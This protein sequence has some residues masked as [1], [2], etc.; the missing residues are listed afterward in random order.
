MG[1]REKLRS[2]SSKPL[3]EN[4][5][6]SAETEELSNAADI[7][8]SSRRTSVFSCEDGAR[9][10]RAELLSMIADTKSP[11][12]LT[13]FPDDSDCR[14]GLLCF[15]GIAV[16]L[17]DLFR[18]LEGLQHRARM[19]ELLTEHISS[20]YEW[21]E[22]FFGIITCIFDTEEDVL[23][24]WIEKV[25]ALAM[26][27]SLAPKR[28]KTKKERTKDLCWD[29]L[30]LKM[31]FEK[32]ASRKVSLTDLIREMTD[33]AEQLGSRILMYI[34]TLVDELP[35]LLNQNFGFDERRLIEAGVMR[36][37][38]ATE[39][40]KFVICAYSRGI[41]DSDKRNGFLEES[42]QSLKSTKSTVPKQ[43]KRFR[44]K[45]TDLADLLAIHALEIETAGSE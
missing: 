3:T 14:L 17:R 30:E 42:F 33:E 4:S 34:Q 5:F 16:E 8:L 28:R 39:P 15:N 26:E 40:G 6:T 36:N 23:F 44:K 32:K 1:L 10:S 25:G 35:D 7:A 19:Q 41:V 38:R 27:N 29:I 11:L 45:H 20:F 31:Q 22:G 37:F 12:D 24:S 21:F 2:V 9:R 43:M 18:I 13:D